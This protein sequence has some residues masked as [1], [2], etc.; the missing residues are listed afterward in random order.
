MRD[1]PD[2][3]RRAIA[4]VLT[5]AIVLIVLTLAACSPVDDVATGWWHAW[6]DSP[7]GEL[8][9]GLVITPSTN[10]FEAMVI[11]G[12]ERLRVDDVRI[13]GENVVIA[14]PHY[15]STIRAVIDRGAGRLDGEWSKRSRNGWS[16]LLAE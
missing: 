9:F 6:L 3:R 10:G 13:D 1:F 12:E 4:S 5:R 2:C 16:R 14:F 11:N 15:D 7:G 8:P